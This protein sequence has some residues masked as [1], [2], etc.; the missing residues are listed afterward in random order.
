[1][2]TLDT[3]SELATHEDTSG[4]ARAD[5]LPTATIVIANF[6]GEADLPECLD[7]IRALDYPADKVETIIVENGSS[8]GSRKLLAERYPWVKVLEQETNLGFAPAVNLGVEAAT[9]ELVALLNNDMQ[10]EPGWLDALVDSY[11][12]ENGY[13]C[14]AGTILDW[15]GEKVD[16]AEGVLNWHGM[17]DQIGFGLPVDQVSITDGK[18]LLFA[19]GGAMLISRKVYLDLGGLDADY[20]A[21]FEDVDLGWRLWLS[22]HKVRLAADARCR[23]RH[24]GTSG[25]FPFYQRA[26]LYERNALRTIIK[27]L[28]DENLG[29]VLAPALLLLIQR[30]IGDT[31]IDRSTF[32]FGA[33]EAGDTTPVP[34]D[35]LARLH[36][37]GDIIGDLDELM[38]LRR[39]VQLRRVADDDAVLARFGRPFRPLGAGGTDYLE[40]SES[41]RRNFQIDRV[42]PEGKATRVAVLA[43]D[44]IG[45]RMAGPAVRSWEIAKALA[46]SYTVTLLSPWEVEREA[47]GVEVLKFDAP[48]ELRQMLVESDVVL[49]HGYALVQYPIL[50][51]TRA[52]LAVDLYDPWIFENLEMRRETIDDR[53][54]DFHL[55]VDVDVQTELLDH[56]D[57][58]V[59]A[60]ERQRDYWLGM[61]TARGRVDRPSYSAD[62]TLRS[63]I[64][65]VPYGCPDTEPS[66][67]GGAPVLRGV[68]PA[69]P[70]DS[71]IVIWGG[72]TWEWFDPVLVLEAF[73]VAHAR[74]P[75]LRLYFM[76]L[77][78]AAGQG[79][80]RMKVAVRLRERAAELGLVDTA[81]VFG[82]WAPY[83][84]RGQYL[85]ESD[86]GII[87]TKDLAEVRLSFRSRLLD[88]FWTGLPT[89]STAGDV[90]ADVV[91][92]NDAG[93]VV[94]IGDRDALAA[95]ILRLAD[96][97]ELRARQSRNARALADRYRWAANVEPLAALAAN[98]A[99]WRAVRSTRATRRQLDLSEDTQILL[100]HRRAMI[101]DYA[102]VAKLFHFVGNSKILRPI[103]RFIKRKVLRIK[104]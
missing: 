48:E 77:D 65:V 84:E 36:G 28:D 29:R 31:K 6:N 66:E 97:T 7:S 40:A 80:P 24:N 99:K 10:V 92:D 82:N 62:P 91:S 12:P 78:Q 87:A 38:R 30:V 8:D 58:F 83:D 14:V 53:V 22:G 3:A 71:I 56:G 70:D 46:K 79:V 81:V 16:Y 34:L 61:L 64:D 2:T 43:Y 4:A 60:S 74:E 51:T 96:D 54:E 19:C 69:I 101:N 26:L 32:D 44:R 1:M 27:N 17:G 55:R 98:P 63:L 23:H 50:K 33:A 86:I 94:P 102:R 21:Y 49:V 85:V 13:T 45:E 93:A 41:I 67:A 5:R 57:F 73:A 68:H 100:L 35:A 103:A 42:F 90:L 37:V 9:G 18:E 20:F 11:D 59:C 89:I 104:N 25:R 75:R 15:S 39:E 52:L 76:G 95:E 72:G 47:P 88:H